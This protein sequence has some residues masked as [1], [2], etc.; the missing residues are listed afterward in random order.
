M[1]GNEIRRLDR[2]ALTDAYGVASQRLLPWAALSAPFEG[3]WCVLGPGAASH[4][5]AHHEHELFIALS[6]RAVLEVDGTP[7][8]FRAGDL[9]CLAP[10]STHSV[11][12]TGEDD[13]EWYAIWWDTAMSAEFSARH[14][15]SARQETGS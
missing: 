4:P 7:R 9:A 8:E 14:G 15:V 5:H 13:F 6:G 2:G 3:A 1:S 10:G 12:N 11:R